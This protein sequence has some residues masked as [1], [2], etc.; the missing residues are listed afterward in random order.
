M[1]KF[2]RVK[3]TQ[4]VFLGDFV[5]RASGRGLV[6]LGI[7][8]PPYNYGQPY[9]AYEDNKSHEAYLNWTREY[10]SR[11]VPMLDKHGALWVF[12][13]DEWVCE[14]EYMMKHEFKLH[15]RQHL[16]WAFTFGV[17]CQGKFSRSHCHMLHMTKTKTKFTFNAD[18]LRVPSARSLVYGDKRAASK[19][20][21]PDATWMLL[22]EQL[23]P[24]MTKE[25]SVWLESRICGTFKERKKHSPNQIPLPIYE[26]I[27]K[28]LTNEGDLVVDPFAGTGGLG[29]VCKRL[30]R[31]YIGFDIGK[32]CV[33]QSNARI[34]AAELTE[35][36]PP[37]KKPKKKR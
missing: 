19:G 11:L 3:T 14:L 20:K 2:K 25:G 27:V 12:V 6:K 4:E 16:I 32:D 24:Y 13:P 9:E 37:S 36:A 35:E 34:R 28:A 1:S 33:K 23:E 22:K 21:L 30:N 7:V 31:N 15:K 29:V 8:D 18:A 26:R 17:A 10:L 5:K